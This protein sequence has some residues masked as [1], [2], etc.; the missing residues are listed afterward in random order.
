MSEVTREEAQQVVVALAM[1]DF[2]ARQRSLVMGLLERCA[3]EGREYVPWRRK[4]IAE[5][6]WTTPQE[7]SRDKEALVRLGILKTNQ[8]GEVG[9]N[10]DVRTWKRPGVVSLAP[11]QAESETAFCRVVLNT[12]GVGNHTGSVGLHTR[13]GVEPH[14]ESGEVNTGGVG[15]HTAGVEHDTGGVEK[16]GIIPPSGGETNVSQGHNRIPSE[17]AAEAPEYSRWR[18]SLTESKNPAAVV[19]ALIQQKLPRQEADWKDQGVNPFSKVGQLVSSGKRKNPHALPSWKEVLR[20]VWQALAD[21]PDGDIVDYVQA[22]WNRER[23]RR[24]AGGQPL[25]GPRRLD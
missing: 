25:T 9:V 22:K 20:Q 6:M 7:A 13:P 24:I 14:T 18:L 8:Y 5:L 15:T 10:P 21:E 23:E 19:V 4:E 1:S 11:R 2:T 12:P 16:P 17:Y 3:R